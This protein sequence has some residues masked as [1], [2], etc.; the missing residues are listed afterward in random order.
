MWVLC[1]AE[2]HLNLT[3]WNFKVQ[4]LEKHLHCDSTGGDQVMLYFLIKG[5]VIPITGL[6]GPEGG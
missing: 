2:T 3:E 6:C 5:K 4:N 1:T